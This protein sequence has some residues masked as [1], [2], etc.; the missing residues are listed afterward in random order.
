MRGLPASVVAKG[1]CVSSDTIIRWY[2]E[3]KVPL[4]ALPRP[5]RGHYRFTRE[6]VEVSIRVLEIK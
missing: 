3:G 2:E 4:V 6:S 5:E 1:F